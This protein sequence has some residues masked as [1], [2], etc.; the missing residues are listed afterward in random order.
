MFNRFVFLIIFLF[1]LSS[2]AYDPYYYID[3]DIQKP[4]KEFVMPRNFVGCP[5]F[6]AFRVLDDGTNAANLSGWSV[7]TM[8]YFYDRSAYEGGVHI[9]SDTISNNVVYFKG[10]TNLLSNPVI[11]S[12]NS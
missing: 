1:A 2:Y 5:P 6:I 4:D 3:V 7:F 10:V 9:P 11:I 8:S 12:F